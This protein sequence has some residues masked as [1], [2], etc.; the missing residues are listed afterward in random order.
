MNSPFQHASSTHPSLGIVVFTAGVMLVLLAIG[1]YTFERFY[2][3]IRTSAAQSLQLIAE[4]KRQGLE[5]L[6]ESTRLEIASFTSGHAQLP[7]RFERWLEGGRQDGELIAQIQGRTQEMAMIRSWRGARAFD[8]QGLE[9]FRVGTF[10]L[11]PSPEQIAAV[12]TS[13]ETQLIDLRQGADGVW[14]YGYLAPIRFRDGPVLGTLQVALARDDQLLRVV[15]SWPLPQT[16]A[17]SLLIR[18]ANGRCEHLTPLRDPEHPLIS[19]EDRPPLLCVQVLAG[20]VGLLEG[21]FSQHGL[22]LLAYAAPI[23][24]TPW[25]LIA[26]VD[27]HEAL[28]LVNTLFW[29]ITLVTATVLALVSII[30]ILFW[31]REQQRRSLAALT[32]Q[33]ATEMRLQTLMSQLPVGVALIET[34]GG[35]IR[36]AN[37]ALARILGTTPQALIGRTWMELTD[38]EDLEFNR[39]QVERFLSGEIADFRLDKRCLRTDGSR[40]WVSLIATRLEPQPSEPPCLLCLIEDISDR[41]AQEAELIEAREAAAR[42]DSEQRLGAIIE[43]GLAGVVELDAWGRFVRVNARYAEILGHPPEALI[44][45]PLREAVLE[46]D[47]P[48]LATFL[49]QLRQG[50]PPE[51]IERRFQ[52]PTGELGYLII[53]ATALRNAQGECTGF[54]ALVSDITEQRRTEESLWLAIENAQ[55]GLWTWDLTTDRI[56]GWGHFQEQFGLPAGTEPNYVEFLECLHPGDRLGFD[57]EVQR[58]KTGQDGIRLEYRVKAPGGWRWLSVR[59]RAYRNP[60]GQVERMSG[61]TLDITERKQLEE[62]LRDSERQFRELNADLERQVAERT[63]EARA[64]STAKSEF[65][66]HMSH[67]IRTPLNAVLGLT[68]LLAR[69]PPLTD[70][71]RKL[72]AHLQDAGES[73]LALINDILDFSKIEA[74]QLRLE[75]RPFELSTV[76]SKIDSLMFSNAQARGLEFIIDLPPEPVGPL[77]GDALRLDQVLLNLISNAIKFTEH[78][79]IWVWIRLVEA[80]DQRVRLR[81]E[82]TDSGIGIEPAFIPRLFQPFTQ[83]H[84]LSSRFGGTG[85]GLSISKRL[86]ELMGGV[87]G[88]ESQLGQGT[89][90]WFEIPFTRAKALEPPPAPAPNPLPASGP[91]FI[92]RHFLVVDDSGINREVVERALK[93]EG[94][95]VALAV[96]GQQAVQILT[97]RSG[98]DAVLMDVRM[99]VMDGLTATRLIREELGLR[100]LPIIALTAGVMAEEQAAIHA[101]GFN[102][103]LPKPFDLEQL[104]QRLQ[105]WIA[106]RPPVAQARTVM[107]HA[108]IG[109]TRDEE[110]D[111]LPKLSG[112]DPTLVMARLGDDPSFLRRLLARFIADYND[113]PARIHHLIQRNACA[114]ARQHLHRLCGESGSLGLIALMNLAERLEFALTQPTSKLGQIE[115][116]LQALKAELDAF[117]TAVSPWVEDQ[118]VQTQADASA[119]NSLSPRRP[120]PRPDP[121]QI[122]ALRQALGANK[123]QARW[124]FEALSPVLRHHLPPLSYQRLDS[125]IRDLRFAEALA[126]LEDLKDPTP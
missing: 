18:R 81:F 87:I 68:Q 64:A 103:F 29:A 76:L 55:L 70:S 44:G 82:V 75:S 63:A 45:R 121:G 124:I 102:D 89:T 107:Q 14:E 30:G 20:K 126:C 12:Q 48:E 3:L 4:Q 46:E 56:R 84:A 8:A 91:R 60:E 117:I 34:E 38:P 114:E 69:E 99:P 86:V 16:T 80:D 5:H 47:W 59:G 58:L 95:E 109:Q 15:Q 43:Q 26:K 36:E 85:L 116:D 6:L 94:A 74:G 97:A 72:I 101:A 98:F 2:G 49:D 10:G 24:G 73:F 42:L 78:G 110:Y 113:L 40:V 61:I 51:I 88:V 118:G 37:A 119:E 11:E 104:I 52:T 39:M 22:P 90:F 115:A 67:E 53:S 93:R 54:M 92:G 31:Y 41:L 71:Q 112:F 106:T 7:E 33:R 96:D 19:A 28:R 62:A 125:A 122:A 105:D 65:L 120:M 17:E 1:G 25:L 77:I 57:Q 27:A 9:V 100:D 50:G 35:R 83:A 13:G 23:A 123:A 32:S 111:K 21:T 66:A 108:T 79:G